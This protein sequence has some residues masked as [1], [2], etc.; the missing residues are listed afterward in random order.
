MSDISPVTSEPNTRLP[1]ELLRQIIRDPDLER[2]DLWSL[3]VS[4]RILSAEAYLALYE[5]VHLKEPRVIICALDTF[6]A[7]SQVAELV[8][9]LV[10]EV[11]PAYF[12][13]SWFNL[14]DKAV[15]AIHNMKNLR[16]LGINYLWASN[17]QGPSLKTKEGVAWTR[18]LYIPQVETLAIDTS[19]YRPLREIFGE[20]R[21][22]LPKLRTIRPVHVDHIDGITQVAC[23]RIYGKRSTPLNDLKILEVFNLES[24]TLENLDWAPH[25]DTVALVSPYISTGNLGWG[26]WCIPFEYIKHVKKIG[27]IFFWDLAEVSMRLDLLYLHLIIT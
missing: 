27:P 20:L 19:T 6:S 22:P 8:H 21:A 11:K 3:S 15:D 7:F 16:E 17:P 12:G 25:L 13:E 24:F 1:P 5:N 2:R 18:K 9:S 26:S 23:E 10:L 14:S 4:S